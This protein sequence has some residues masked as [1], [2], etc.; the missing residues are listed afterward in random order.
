[1]RSSF[2]HTKLSSYKCFSL[3]AT[4]APAYFTTTN[5]PTMNALAYF[6]TENFPTMNALAY[7]TTE[8]FPTMNALAYF[9]SNLSYHE[10]SCCVCLIF[11]DLTNIL[12]PGHNGQT[13]QRDRS[14][15]P[16]PTEA[17]QVLLG[18]PDRPRR[19]RPVG[20]QVSPRALHRKLLRPC[21]GMVRGPRLSRR[22]HGPS[23][24]RKV[25]GRWIFLALRRPAKCH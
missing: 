14:R 18:G 20:G 8:N 4:N 5:F 24:H 22:R 9:T 25:R 10:C 11:S 21:R 1:M 17:Q 16:L 12:I 19:P 23:P 2:G 7:S 6:T 3:L 15:R 13:L